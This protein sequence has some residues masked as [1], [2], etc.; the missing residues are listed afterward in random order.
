MIGPH[1]QDNG[2]VRRVID[3]TFVAFVGFKDKEFAFAGVKVADG[4]CRSTAFGNGSVEKTGF[5]SAVCKGFAHVGGHSTLAAA[6][7]YGN[8]GTFLC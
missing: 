7:C 8:A 3:Q 6:S 5:I 4:V 1:I 2:I